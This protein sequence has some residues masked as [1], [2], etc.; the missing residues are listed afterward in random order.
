MW[1]PP[2]NAHICDTTPSAPLLKY[3]E[4]TTAADI[5]DVQFYLY[6]KFKS[7]ESHPSIRVTLL[8]SNYFEKI[9]KN[10]P[11]ILMFYVWDPKV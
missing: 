7:K 1:F 8:T 3:L 10:I 9:E 11:Y 6:E 5:S 2:G 4:I